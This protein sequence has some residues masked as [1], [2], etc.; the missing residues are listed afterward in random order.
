MR[1]AAVLRRAAASAQR[2]E[3][4]ARRAA[5]KDNV[6]E[7]AQRRTQD[8]RFNIL[9]QRWGPRCKVNQRIQRGRTQSQ[10]DL[11]QLVR[12]LGVATT[13]RAP[14]RATLLGAGRRSRRNF[15]RKRAA[16]GAGSRVFGGR[17]RTAR[18]T[19][20]RGFALGRNAGDD[21]WASARFND[22]Q[23]GQRCRDRPGN[24]LVRRSRPHSVQRT[25]SGR[26]RQVRNR[27]SSRAQSL[28]CSRPESPVDSIFWRNKR[29][30]R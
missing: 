13:Q 25:A 30:N 9:R 26:A 17:R 2:R 7:M 27:W 19:G 21:P 29:I 14:Y 22:Q 15:F 18:I 11:Q 8:R 5:R 10:R 6:D 28:C 20:A 4:S 16:R 3:P 1:R 23:Q 24:G 12:D